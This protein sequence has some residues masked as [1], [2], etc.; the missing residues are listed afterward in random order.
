ME[1]GLC[2]G[3][4]PVSDAETLMC[5][6]PLGSS[7][8]GFF[9]AMVG[10]Q[11]GREPPHLSPISP[12]SHGRRRRPDLPLGEPL[13]LYHP[14]PAPCPDCGEPSTGTWG[15]SPPTHSWPP[16][17]PDQGVSSMGTWGPL[18][19]LLWMVNSCGFSTSQ[20][21][22]EPGSWQGSRK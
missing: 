1:G 12:R 9:P 5:L 10:T 2:P 7:H 16:A 14:L 3:P 8:T 13:P 21:P 18:H 20:A 15:T 4:S 19:H 11:D 17:R 6:L 22:V